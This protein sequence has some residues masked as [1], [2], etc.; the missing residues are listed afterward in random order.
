[1]YSVKKELDVYTLFKLYIF[2]GIRGES[3]V[4]KS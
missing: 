1:V 2:N 4:L 3:R